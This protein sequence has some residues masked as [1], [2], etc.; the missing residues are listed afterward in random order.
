MASVH[1][2]LEKEGEGLLEIQ[3]LN[4]EFLNSNKASDSVRRYLEEASENEDLLLRFLRGR[5]YRSQHA[6]DT[7]KR[8]AEVRFD[9]YPEVFPEAFPEVLCNLKENPILGVLKS[10]D[11]LGRR[12]LFTDATKWNP[13]QYPMEVFTIAFVQLAEGL[14][15]DEDG[16][17]N[18]FVYI[19][20]CSGVGMKLVREYS[21]RAIRRL[22][23]VF[24]YAFP[25]KIK[26]IYYVN[27]PTILSCAFEIARPFLTKKIKERLHIVGPGKDPQQVYDETIPLDILPKCLGGTLEI[28]E[29]VD[30]SFFTFLTS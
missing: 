10:R 13:D 23:N 27:V 29:A 7:L 25:L 2:S 5:K 3:R 16:L 19:Q 24:W 15:L 21:L 11:S 1:G 17:N 18:G 26:V 20:Q 4:K 30:S 12:I 28:H 22:V 6:W 9:L 14:L 8:Y